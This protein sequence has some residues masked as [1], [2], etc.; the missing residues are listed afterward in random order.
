MLVSPHLSCGLVG[1]KDM[2][3]W[4]NGNRLAK[5]V[6]GVLE[7]LFRERR[8]ALGLC[9]GSDRASSMHAEATERTINI[10]FIFQLR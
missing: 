10:R 6:N 2:V 3:P 7:A 9:Q 5:E 8:I 1:V 4:V